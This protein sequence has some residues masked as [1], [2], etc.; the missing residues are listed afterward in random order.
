MI[1]Y[2]DVQELSS[3]FDF[4]CG[5]DIGLACRQISGWMVVRQDN[6]AGTCFKSSD[7]DQFQ[8]DYCPSDAASGSS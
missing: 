1:E 8:I 2:L 7:E 5:R 4:T 3:V 6:S